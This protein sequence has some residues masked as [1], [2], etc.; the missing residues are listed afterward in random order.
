MSIKHYDFVVTGA[1]GGVARRLIPILVRRG[2]RILALGRD[3]AALEKLYADILGVEVA[4]Y[5]DVTDSM[6]CDTLIHLAVRNNNQPGSVKEFVGANVEIA[7]QACQIFYRIGGRRFVNISSIQSLDEGNT[8]P[9]AIS[10]EVA[11]QQIAEFV[12]GQLDNVYVGY[13]H[14]D[15]YFGR[16]LSWLSRLGLFGNVFFA[17]LRVLKPATSVESLADYITKPVHASSALVILTDDLSQ[18]RLYR[19]IVRSLDLSVALA[20][21]II[22][23]PI[24]LIFWLAIRLDSPGPAIFEQNRVGKEQIPFKL[25]KFRTMRRDTVAAATH[26]VSA[27]AVTNIGKFLRRTKL[28]ELPQ[29]I[30]LLRGD[31]TLVGPRP[32]LPAQK[33]LVQARQLL[34]VFAMKPG[35][36]GYAQIRGIDMRY[37]HKLAEADFIYMSLKS[38]SLN[39]KI[40]LF[41]AFGRGSGDRVASFE[42]M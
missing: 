40:M 41:T 4:R 2:G 6:R 11:R 34:G 17:A 12:G 33:E 26:E 29:A 5:G 42:R 35:I 15:K 7:L 10:K 24:Y 8:S 21:L 9:Y 19:T 36:T 1:S 27:N 38:L 28:D 16:R 30:N 25:Y 37:P 31:M 3:A 13:L 23:V 14:D 32:C 22:L 39:L 18:H 20:V